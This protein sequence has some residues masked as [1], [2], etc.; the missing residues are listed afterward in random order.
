L[1]KINPT[2]CLILEYH[3]Q[4]D[5]LLVDIHQEDLRQIDHHQA[6]HP[7]EDRLKGSYPLPAK[8]HRLITLLQDHQ[9]SQEDQ[10]GRECLQLSAVM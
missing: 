9:G 8:R 6:D 2:P 5:T 1:N 4:V 10:E 3:L 7:Q